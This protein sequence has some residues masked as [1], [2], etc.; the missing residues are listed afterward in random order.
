MLLAGIFATSIQLSSA[1]LRYLPFSRELSDETIS[2][3]RK[4]LLAAG[5]FSLAWN[6][7]VF[8]DGLT[9][10]AYRFAM[11]PGWLPYVLA[12]L[13]VIRKKFAQH[14][15]IIGMQFLWTFMLHALAGMTVAFFYGT[16]AE[17]LI[18]LQLFIYLVLFTI[19]FPLERK[20]FINL[21]PS[22]R[23]FADKSLRRSIAGLPILIF[24]GAMI[25]ISDV[26]FFPTWQDKF[27]HLILPAVFLL[28]Y[29]S[30]SLATRQ[31]EEKQ[32]RE[33]KNRALQR[34]AESMSEHNALMEK[35]QLEVAE[36]RADLEKNYF[37][38]EKFLTAGKQ[39]EAMKFI[40]RQT[41]FLDSTR[42]KTFCLSP[43]INAA[44]SI[45]LSRAEKFG[46]KIFHKIEWPA[47]SST[48]END[49]AVL[50]SNLLENAIAASKKN[51]ADKKI[52]VILR[53]SGEQNILE[54][55]NRFDFPIKIG[56]NGLPYTS[57]IGHGLGMASLELFAKKYDAF[58]DFSHEEK[59]VR[60][61]VY[62]ND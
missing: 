34:Q 7:F 16:M 1:Y 25:G 29:R 30:L 2:L 3:L 56:E 15:F 44:L 28:I 22:E 60:L 18:P 21:L 26:V 33:R 6:V 36:L 54:I 10:R 41:K 45:H 47:R 37:A 4:S 23:L 19:L 14:L 24:F 50:I 58:V 11:F 12:S 43:L 38:I 32:L 42:V 9:Y 5:A 51:P 31:V 17:E 59:I 27:S 55:E 13:I 35:S 49:L 52:S 46:I 53:N 39:A 40:R 62:W 20:F 48:D 8:S 61:S 57:E